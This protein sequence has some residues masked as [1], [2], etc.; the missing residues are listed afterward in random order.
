MSIYY[1]GNELGSMVFEE[2]TG[3]DLP[4]VTEADNGKILKVVNGAWDKADDEWKLVLDTVINDNPE[5]QPLTLDYETGVMTFADA[6]PTTN[7]LKPQ[8]IIPNFQTGDTLI[9]AWKYVP[10]EFLTIGLLESTG[11]YNGKTTIVSGGVNQY[12]DPSKFHFEQISSVAHTWNGLNCN[13][14]KFELLAPNIKVWA[15]N[16]NIV[17]NVLLSDGTT[18]EFNSAYDESS[19]HAGLFTIAM[20]CCILHDTLWI[21]TERKK[22]RLSN[23]T[24]A[25]TAGA[26]ANSV[27]CSN[28]GKK[29]TQGVTIA[30]ITTTHR[31]NQQSGMYNGTIIRI[32]EG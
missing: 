7:A 12:V 3:V 8:G 9:D 29:V 32:W 25:T 17:F 27:D 19:Q 30:G 11:I 1:Q 20:E 21:S 14:L 15:W 26:F 5:Y 4:E 22:Y 18:I 28:T 23:R 10:N 6:L 24:K 2:R 13:K 31:D 16:A